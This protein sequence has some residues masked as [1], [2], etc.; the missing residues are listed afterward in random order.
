[1]CD[2]F[3]DDPLLQS[4]STKNNLPTRVLIYVDFVLD[5]FEIPANAY[6]L[7][8]NSLYKQLNKYIT[9]FHPLRRTYTISFI[10]VELVQ[11]IAMYECE[12]RSR[13]VISML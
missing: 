10:A 13:M 5:F 12:V 11:Y 1:M 4:L 7:V 3:L 6:K 2:L 8:C 9:S